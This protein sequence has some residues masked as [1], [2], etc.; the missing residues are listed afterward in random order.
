MALADG[1]LPF[2]RPSWAGIRG[3]RDTQTLSLVRFPRLPLSLDPEAPKGRD[4]G[5]VPACGSQLLAQAALESWRGPLGSAWGPQT[6]CCDWGNRA[7]VQQNGK[8][9]DPERVLAFLRG[10]GRAGPGAA[11]TPGGP[12]GPGTHPKE[13]PISRKGALPGW[14]P[15]SQRRVPLTPPFTHS[16]GPAF[17]PVSSDRR[18]GH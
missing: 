3:G 4:Q 13:T 18:P 16:L 5:P 6:P 17:V 2:G 9:P 10:K 15:C 8:E 7:D 12:W 11:P 14:P 1:Y